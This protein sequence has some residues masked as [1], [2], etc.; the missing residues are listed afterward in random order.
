MNRFELWL[1]AHALACKL[2]D[3]YL[4]A[5]T[6][7]QEWRLGRLMGMAFRRAYRRGGGN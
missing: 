1:Q 3:A 2:Y 5:E 7:P 6:A 4:S